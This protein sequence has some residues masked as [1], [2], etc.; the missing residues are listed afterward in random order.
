MPDSAALTLNVGDPSSS[1]EVGFENTH[2]SAL[3]FESHA[4]IQEL[5]LWLALRTA[6]TATLSVEGTTLGDA[7]AYVDVP[8]M[9][10]HVSPVSNV[11]INC[12]P[13]SQSST[14]DKSDAGD[15]LTQPI[16]V[17]VYGSLDY[18]AYA[19]VSGALFVEVGR[20]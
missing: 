20:C 11:D 6:V 14:S 13:L 4:S 7:G 17:D 3:P 16:K 5:D 2:F 15:I 12:V 18:G 1:S 10:A 9:N 19:H 8:R